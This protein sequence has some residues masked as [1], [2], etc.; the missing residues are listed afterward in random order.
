MGKTLFI[1]LC[2][3]AIL[4]MVQGVA[5]QTMTDSLTAYW[6]FQGNCYDNVS[7]TACSSVG[8]SPQYVPAIVGNGLNFSNPGAGL[9][10]LNRTTNDTGINGSNKKT[11]NMWVHSAGSWLNGESLL[12]VNAA[13]C[14]T[15]DCIFLHKQSGAQG[16]YR[17]TIG[18]VDHD[19]FSGQQPETWIMLTLVYNGTDLIFYFNGSVA[20]SVTTPIDTA[21]LQMFMSE[22][23][24]GNLLNATIDEFSVY[25]T[26]LSQE[27]ITWLYNNG[28]GRSYQ[29]HLDTA[30]IP[31]TGP[32]NVTVTPTNNM[33]GGINITVFNATF[34]NSTAGPFVYNGSGGI[35]TTD[36]SNGSGLWNVT[37]RADDFFNYTVEDFDVVVGDIPA[38]MFQ[39]V[40]TCFAM[41]IVSGTTITNF[42]CTANQ[43][44]GSSSNGSMNLYLDA[45][46]YSI[47]MS[48]AGYFTENTTAEFSALTFNN[49]TLELG[50]ALIEFKAKTFLNETQISGIN[51]TLTSNNYTWTETRVTA[52]S[53]LNWSALINGSYNITI[54]SDG[55]IDHEG[56][57]TVGNESAGYQ[58][59]MWQA[60]LRVTAIDTLS[61]AAVS[62]FTVVDQFNTL[63]NASGTQAVLYLDATDWN[64]TIIKDGYLNQSWL[65]TAAALSNE[66]T[67]RNISPI[68]NYSIIDEATGAA[69]N[70]EGMDSVEI[71]IF[72]DNE[73]LH[74]DFKDTNDSHLSLG[75]GCDYF[76]VK[77]T[78]EL[79]GSSYFRTLVPEEDE[80]NVQFYMVD[81]NTDIAV[82]RILNLVD[83]TGDYSEGTLRATRFLNG[84]TR[85]IIKQPFDIEDSVTLYMMKDELYVLSLFDNSDAERA[86]GNLIA[87]SAGEQ[88]VTFPQIDFY[89]DMLLGDEVGWSYDINDTAGFLRVVYQDDSA[90]TTFVQFTVFNATY[91]QLFQSSSN[92]SNVTF[93]FNGIVQNTTYVSRFELIHPL[94]N[95]NETRTWHEGTGGIVQLVGWDEETTDNILLAVSILFLFTWMMMFSRVHAEFGGVTTFIWMVLLKW[96]GW[97]DI[98][99][100]WLMI[101]GIVAISAFIARGTKR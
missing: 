88:T 97:F 68:I 44:F 17:A 12:T 18:G 83:L 38:S 81:L 5:A 78:M 65:H 86:L 87:D 99:F 73:T 101:A 15:L 36:I 32:Q 63:W 91:G 56:S 57:F 76:V 1:G 33:T 94:G 34:R 7:N 70:V 93:T 98:N 72:C 82:Q 19:G 59:T 52:D 42:N 28:A 22:D 10:T 25:D 80:R 49:V 79:N 96:M 75:V 4:V 90:S 35:L 11:L 58:A 71:D 61:D 60:E 100:I 64:F 54:K 40:V 95:V 31:P 77:M 3:I 27:N 9:V 23:I 21:R 2:A 26:S 84:A 89:P 45:G 55:F 16:K 14:G 85:D 50:T 6:D 13:S 74:G 67:I 47:N 46:N 29:D 43:A 62:D 20:E 48:A 66:S 69:F 53:S 41:E 51:V 8:G 92:L 24:T 30:Q 39:S 37:V